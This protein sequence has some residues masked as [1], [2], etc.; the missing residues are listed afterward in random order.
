MGSDGT[1]MMLMSILQARISQLS[2]QLND[3]RSRDDLPPYT[4]LELQRKLKDAE[5]EIRSLEKSIDRGK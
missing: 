1:A 2:A 3:A 4:K 5:R